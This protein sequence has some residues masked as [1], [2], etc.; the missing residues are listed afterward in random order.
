V[1]EWVVDEED[2]RQEDRELER[3]DKRGG[4]DPVGRGKGSMRKA[5]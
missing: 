4:L 2:E 3:V 1:A 5:A